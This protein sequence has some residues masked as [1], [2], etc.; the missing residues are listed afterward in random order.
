MQ[1]RQ[2]E[3]SSAREAIAEVRKVM[4]AS[5]IILS[6]SE[7]RVNGECHVVVTAAVDQE[8][9]PA[10]PVAVSRKAMGKAGDLSETI[11]WFSD[12]DEFSGMDGDH[13]KSTLFLLRHMVDDAIQDR[14]RGYEEN[15]ARKWIDL[16]ITRGVERS[17]AY[18]LIHKLFSRPGRGQGGTL[19]FAQLKEVLMQVLQVTGEIELKGSTPRFVVFLGPPGV[20]KTTT[21]AKMVARLKRRTRRP[22]VLLST[23]VYRIG[24]MDQ[25]YIYGD[26]M[27]VP[28]EAIRSKK[29]LQRVYKAYPKGALFLVDT[30]GRS[31]SDDQGLME[32]KILVDDMAREMQAFLLL[33]AGKKQKDLLEEIKGF[34][35][36]PFQSLIWTKMDETGMPGEIVNI[37]LRTKTPVSYITTG[38]NV[39]GD[40]EVADPERLVEIIL[41][42]E[43]SRRFLWTRR[44]NY[45]YPKNR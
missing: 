1:I 41:T 30:T 35:L 34:S 23:D 22:L 16:L 45:D 18:L 8:T 42:D 20:G 26:L 13:L 25:L 4:G 7:E 24:A 29:D 21:L 28:V 11:N 5:A 44:Q 12:K 15:P 31:H 32:I 17:T 3:A 19:S 6:T 27:G 2:F 9:Q 43:R 39:P 36:F 40:M 14:V 10:C 38:Q 37:M 33:D